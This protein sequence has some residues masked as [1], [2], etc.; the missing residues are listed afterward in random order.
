M[1]DDGAIEMQHFDGTLEEAE[2]EGWIAMLSEPAEP[3]EDWTGSVDISAEDAHGRG[4]SLVRDWQN[5]LEQIEE[6][7]INI[8]QN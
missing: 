5:E 6:P 4:P 7:E 1:D 8:E 2:P 3:P